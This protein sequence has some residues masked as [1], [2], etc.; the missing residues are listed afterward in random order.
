MAQ[1]NPRLD[2][3]RQRWA[4]S[5][6]TLSLSVDLEEQ[7]SGHTLSA[8]G[9]CAV[10]PPDA[11]RLQLVG[12]AGSL[13]MDLWIQ[14]DRARLALPVLDRVEHA[15]E[16]FGPGRPTA[17]LRWWLLGPLDGEIVQVWKS[18]QGD[19][20]RWA[21]RSPREGLILVTSAGESLSLERSSGEAR[22]VIE[23][24]GGP[25]GVSSYR[26]EA[27]HL[28]VQLRCEGERSSVAPRAFED[29]EGPHPPAPSP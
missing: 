1:A 22:E 8:R 5:S 2:A 17:F 20:F 28:T 29:P 10:R 16:A 4:P 12:P 19:A 7:R 6:R 3:L 13:A 26:S 11:L 15:P 21:L 14:G 25:C 18:S 27:A 9:A 24:R 23:A